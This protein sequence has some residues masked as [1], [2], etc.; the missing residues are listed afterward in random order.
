MFNKPTSDMSM[1][2]KIEGT[3]PVEQATERKR[4][5]TLSFIF[6]FL[7]PTDIFFFWKFYLFIS[8]QDYD[9]DRTFCSKDSRVNTELKLLPELGLFNI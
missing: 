1:I 2:C 9:W 4:I 6:K 3:L 8:K 5:K 7:N